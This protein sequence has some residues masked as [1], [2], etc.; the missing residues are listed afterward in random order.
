MV[1]ENN[2]RLLLIAWLVL[3][4]GAIFAA[5]LLINNLVRKPGT[6]P[7]IKD[8]SDTPTECTYIQKTTE[9]PEDSYFRF[10]VTN[11]YGVK[12][13]LII[14]YKALVVNNQFLNDLMLSVDEYGETEY[15]NEKECSLWLKF[16]IKKTDEEKY[17]VVAPSAEEDDPN[18]YIPVITLSIAEDE[19]GEYTEVVSFESY[20]KDYETRIVKMN[21]CGGI[22]C[23]LSLLL[24]G[25]LFSQYYKPGW[26]KNFKRSQQADAEDNTDLQTDSDDKK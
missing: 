24:S 14:A 19:H 4:I 11:S 16:C 17:N 5:L 12:V 8:Y 1:T 6:E 9:N 2:K 26:Y 3:A 18:S 25:F 7:N 10:T 22:I 23:G 20:K 13:K 15:V 21:V